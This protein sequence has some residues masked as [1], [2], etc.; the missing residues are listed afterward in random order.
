MRA[1]LA[2]SLMIVATVG[3]GS[4]AEA[5]DGREPGTDAPTAAAEPA[6]PPPKLDIDGPPPAWIE[7][8]EGSFWLGYSTY[9]WETACGDYVPP[10]CGESWVPDVAV[11]RGEVVRFHLGY[12]PKRVSLTF[13]GGG[14]MTADIGPASARLSASLAPT[15][16]VTTDGAVSLSAP[17][18]QGKDASYV[19]CLRFSDDAASSSASAV[20]PGL[21]VEEALA[22]K[23]TEPLLIRGGLLIEGDQVRL[24]SGFAESSPPQC[25]GAYLV[26][27]GLDLSTVEGLVRTGGVASAE[28]KLVGTVDDGVLTVLKAT[29]G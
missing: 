29:S 4:E 18:G 15:W 25:T 22:A 23:T 5:P 10:E 2:L 9:C 8:S 6:E 14:T 27:K 3:C 11:R 17:A 26:V 28:V 1:L 24:C 13:F 7:T 21:S 19:A 16:T 20:G 12:D